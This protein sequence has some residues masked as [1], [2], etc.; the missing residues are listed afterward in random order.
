MATASRFMIRSQRNTDQQEK[1]RAAVYNHR[2]A[3]QGF[4]S[5]FLEA[6]AKFQMSAA[7][8]S[9]KGNG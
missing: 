2:Q 3:G 1:I 7:R 8:Q 9:T 4:F 5:N 6:R